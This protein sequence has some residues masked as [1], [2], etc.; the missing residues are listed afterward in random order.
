MHRGCMSNPSRDN[1]LPFLEPFG[2][3]A[4][5]EKLAELL[6]AQAPFKDLS[7]G[8]LK[9]LARYM[10]GFHVAPGKVLFREGDVGDFLCVILEGRVRIVKRDSHDKEK[11]IAAHGPGKTLGE[12]AVVDGERR[13]ATCIAAEPTAIAILTRACFDALTREFP[14][15]AVAVLVRLARILSQRL[16]LTSGQLVDYL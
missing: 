13:S 5:P 4:Q 3:A 16:R 11:E 9:T 7:W 14:G 10:Q 2:D 1:P 12:M 15:L 6:G 8:E